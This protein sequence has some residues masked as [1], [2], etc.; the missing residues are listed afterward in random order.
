MYLVEGNT[1]CADAPLAPE[2]LPSEPWEDF[3]YSCLSHH[4]ASCCDIAREWVLAMD[5]AQLNGADLTSGPRWI[6]AKYKWGPSAW[7]MHWCEAVRR[8]VID[9]GVHAALAR[10]AFTARGLVAFPAQ[11]VQRYTTDATDQWRGS[12]TEEGASCHW[13]DGEHIYH[14]VTALLAGE[15]EVKIWDGSAGSWVDPSQPGG[16]YGS[17]VAMRIFADPQFVK[18]GGFAWGQRRIEAN[19]WNQLGG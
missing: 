9:C 14:E 18:P 6:R 10:E 11:L 3:P 15:G 2:R 5:F 7:P 12:W 13:L 19:V 16:G 4:G 1:A 17:V 8:K